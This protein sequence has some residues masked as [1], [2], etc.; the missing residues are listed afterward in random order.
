MI[1]EIRTKEESRKF[2]INNNLNRVPE[3][4]VQ[5]TQIAEIEEFFQVNNAELYVLRDAEHSSAHYEYVKTIEEC[6]EKIKQ[7]S[8]RVIIAVSINS[9]KNKVLLGAI[10]IYGSDVRICATTNNN[11]DHRTMYD[12]AE[13]RY[14]TDLFDKRLNYIPKFDDIYR[15]VSEHNLFGY[16]VEFTIYDRKVG[17][18]NENIV[19]NEV[20]N[21]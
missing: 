7:F 10:E 11:L 6:F 19:I 2:I 18:N 21:Y 4:F 12:S 3:I 8:G 20:R 14:Q 13:F 1:N 9:Y 16:T 5:S 17:S 15:Y